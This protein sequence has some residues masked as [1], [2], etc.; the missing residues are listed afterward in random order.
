MNIYEFIW[1]NIYIY[2]YLFFSNLNRRDG[3]I[4]ANFRLF[5][6]ICVIITIITTIIYIL[7]NLYTIYL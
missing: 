2:F 7:Y 3:V 1:F 5:V 4:P 6:D